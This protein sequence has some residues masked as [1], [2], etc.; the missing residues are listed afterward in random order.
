M[1]TNFRSG[2][3]AVR[4]PLSLGRPRVAL[5]WL[6]DCDRLA[7]GASH[8]DQ[9]VYEALESKHLTDADALVCLGRDGYHPALSGHQEQRLGRQRRARSRARGQEE[10]LEEAIANAFLTYIRQSTACRTTPHRGDG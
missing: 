1:P 7:V 8:G 4:S 5:L 9:N 10:L 2:T 3:L 6:K